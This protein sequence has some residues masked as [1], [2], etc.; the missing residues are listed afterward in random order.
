M[1]D[2]DPASGETPLVPR[3]ATAAKGSVEIPDTDPFAEEAFIMV[4][5]TLARSRLARAVQ[6]GERAEVIEQ[7][8]REYQAARL[9]SQITSTAPCLDEH[10]RA[11]LAELVLTGGKALES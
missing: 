6:A 4:S 9:A 2:E 3:K 7:L 5:W 8:R 1:H 10:Q 11:Q